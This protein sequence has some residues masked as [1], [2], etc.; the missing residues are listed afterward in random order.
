MNGIYVANRTVSRESERGRERDVQ[1]VSIEMV[2]RRSRRLIVWTFGLEEKGR[3]LEKRMSIR[4]NGRYIG[5][6]TCSVDSGGREYGKAV[7]EK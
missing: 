5:E 3:V 7:K 1:C 2:C 6:V 4:W